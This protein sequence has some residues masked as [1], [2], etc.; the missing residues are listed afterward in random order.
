L[1]MHKY[2][3]RTRREIRRKELTCPQCER[4]DR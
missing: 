3:V 2:V 4:G 1:P